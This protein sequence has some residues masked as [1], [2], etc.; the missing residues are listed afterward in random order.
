M[1]TKISEF[2]IAASP[3]TGTELVP[4][5]QGGGT[6][7]STVENFS[8]AAATYIAP[9]FASK[10]STTGGTIT[11]NTST[12]ALTIT[13]TGGGAALLVED[14]ASPDI[15]PFIVSSNGSV[16]IGTDAPVTN[17]DVNSPTIASARLFASTNEVDFRV[18]ASGG[19]ENL[20]TIS[21]ISNHGIAFKTVGSEKVRITT[22]GKV[23]IGTDAPDKNFV[24]SGIQPSASIVNTDGAISSLAFTPASIASPIGEIDFGGDYPARIRA[25]GNERLRITATGNVGIGTASP[26]AKL[27]VAGN[28]A[29]AGALSSILVNNTTTESTTIRLFRSQAGLDK[30]NWE[31]G[32]LTSADSDAFVI[33]TATDSLAS[34]ET[35]IEV[36]KKATGF[37]VDNIQLF[38]NGGVQRAI[39]TSSGSVIFGTATTTDAFVLASNTSSGG[40][41]ASRVQ[42]LSSTTNSIARFEAYAS[43]NSSYGITFGAVYNASTPYSLIE[44]GSFLS[45][46]MRFNAGALGSPFLFQSQGTEVLRI[47]STGSVGIGQASPVTKLDITNS[48]LA[49]IRCLSSTVDFRHVASATGANSILGNYSNHDVL[50]YTNT[51]ERMRIDTSGRVGI[52]ASFMGTDQAR[53]LVAGGSIAVQGSITNSASNSLQLSYSSGVGALYGYNVSFGSI[54]QFYTNPAGASSSTERMRIDNIGNVGIGTTSPTTF[55]LTIAKSAGTACG[56]RFYSG[57]DYGDLYFSSLDSGV[58]LVN[59]NFSGSNHI[60]FVM[61]GGE[62]FRFNVSGNLGMRTSSF[63]TGAVGVLAIA[64]GTSPSTSPSGVGQI[65]VSGG[66]LLY[67]G[68][69]G[70]VTV[71]A[72]A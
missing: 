65:Y 25:N 29:V 3:L 6:V 71:L 18:S 61:A 72:P 39:F 62:C 59:S 54:L 67:R 70:T 2:P 30:K 19:S 22:D 43:G 10:L 44:N 15:T 7:K 33:R 57:T 38:T 9:Q 23:G 66:A 52:G 5:V 1:G 63:G 12:P 35:A 41:V 47:T 31:I 4:V 56:M 32:F 27:D 28:V 24:V 34:F 45:G 16:G 58:T 64:N 14:S 60:K 48:S 42:N 26:A 40:T 55:G 37:G 36:N 51:T 46:G 20:G 21:T 50:F 69:S 53:L 13:Q 17:L 49:D 11:A 68:S 8:I